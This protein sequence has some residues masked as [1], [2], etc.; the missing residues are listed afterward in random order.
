VAA[1]VLAVALAPAM[2]GGGR[3]SWRLAS[4]TLCIVSV[5]FLVYLIVA[6][7]NGSYM[8]F[9]LLTELWAASI[10]ITGVGFAI[11]KSD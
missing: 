5:Y 2:H 4:A 9:I 3:V 6:L 7:T 1:V 8:S 10:T 11:H